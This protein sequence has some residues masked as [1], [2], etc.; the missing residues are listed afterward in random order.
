M[1]YQSTT[2]SWPYSLGTL[3]IPTRTQTF[4][5]VLEP[6]QSIVSIDR[7]CIKLENPPPPIRPSPLAT[8]TTKLPACNPGPYAP[9][10]PSLMMQ[11]PQ[12]TAGKGQKVV[13]AHAPEPYDSTK[14]MYSGLEVSPGY[15]PSR[16]LPSPRQPTPQDVCP[17]WA[18]PHLSTNILACHCHHS[19]ATAPR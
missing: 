16:T 7:P 12:S 13:C 18:I 15:Q 14:S 4:Q 17:R 10:N 9:Y 19:P 2:F 5:G 3:P 6:N 8:T 11:L 1:A